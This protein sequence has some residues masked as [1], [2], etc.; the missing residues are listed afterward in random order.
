MSGQTT[1][2]RS[3]VHVQLG[4]LRSEDA[5]MPCRV[6]A[7]DLDGAIIDPK[8]HLRALVQLGCMWST[9]TLVQ[10]VERHVR[11][12]RA[13]Q[14]RQWLRAIMSASVRHAQQRVL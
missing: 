7:E 11:G 4:V 3:D 1:I 12:R 2:G 6:E 14:K 5:T 8:A 9:V 13:Q 10:H